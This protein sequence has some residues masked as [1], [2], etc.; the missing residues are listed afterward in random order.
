MKIFKLSLLLMIAAIFCTGC[1]EYKLTVKV[2]SDGS[3]TIHEKVMLGEAFTE[4]MTSLMALGGEETNEEFSMYDEEQ[5]I[6]DASKMGKSVK[7]IKGEK[8][9]E[10]TREG[11]LAIYSFNDINDLKLEQDPS[12]VMPMGDMNVES[13]SDGNPMTFNF[14]KGNPSELTVFL[15]DEEVGKGDQNEYET[16]SEY[17]NEEFNEEALEELRK[18]VKD[19][20]III[21][22]E[23]DGNIVGTNATHVKENLITLVDMNFDKMLDSPE[24]LAELEKYKNAEMSDLKEFLKEIP[25]IKFELKEK[26]EINF[27]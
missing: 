17:E 27:N 25:G 9:S 22:L 5:L 2:K 12:D 1:I 14:K 26:I 7:F 15:P 3:G 11:Y 23:V 13:E 18:Y 10:K 16:S 8:I 19:F 21:K 4:M 24:K 6:A 20:R